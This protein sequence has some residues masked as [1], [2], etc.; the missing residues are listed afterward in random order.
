MTKY[1]IDVSKHN[2]DI[3][4]AHVKASG[5][6]DFAIIR[7]GYGKTI[8]QKDEKFERNYTGCKAQEIPCGVY[9]YSY[10]K[11][12]E[13]AKLEA[14]VFLQVIKGKQFEYPVYLDLEEAFQFAL[15][16]TKVSEMA[17]TFMDILEKAG[18]YVGLYS[19]KSHLESY[20]TEDILHRYT[21]WVAHYGVKETNYR[22]PYALWQYSESGSVSGITGKVD[23]NLCYTVDFP[24]AVKKLGLN[25]FEKTTP[26]VTSEEP[27]K[28][29][30]EVKMWFDDHEYSGLLEEM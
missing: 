25:G 13:E 9:W 6:V 21:I 7:A 14:N 11:S 1:G 16:K 15:G 30:V 19:S 5:K 8:S 29:K 27:G 2:G 24:E 28:K 17:K 4:W 18:Y 22:Y 10:A 12:V 26:I 23:L 3:N 20:F